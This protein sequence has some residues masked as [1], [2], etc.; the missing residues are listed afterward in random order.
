VNSPVA[1]P[2]FVL[3][4]YIGPE[5]VG[6]D[7]APGFDVSNYVVAFGTFPTANIFLSP[8]LSSPIT[9]EFSASIGNQLG[10]HGMAKLTY[11]N[12]SYYNFIEDFIDD[13]TASGRTDVVYNGTDFGTFDNIVYRNSDLPERQYHAL[14]T[15]ANY[16]PWSRLSL[17]G[18]WTLQLKNNGNFEGEAQN[19]PGISSSLGDYP[20]IL[21]PSRNFPLGRLSGFQRN[22]V[23]LW[24]IYDQPLGKFGSVD[25]APILRVDSGTAYSLFATNVDLSDVQLARDPGYAHLPD[26]GTQTLYFGDRGSQTFPGFALFDLAA[27]YQVPV[28]RTASPWIKV[29]ILNVT[30]NQKLIS[31]DTTVTPDPDSP[32]DANGLPTG[33]IKGPRFG[34]ATANTNYPAWRPGQS[35][36]RTYLLSAGVRF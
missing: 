14:L 10:T 36:G 31:W 32:V 20:E 28:F 8:G 30:N 26:G 33:Y 1:N 23:R 19:Q 9:R 21:V 17:E 34:E 24:A 18:H 6:R 25:L 2:A 4:D 7:F 29:E 12:R 35:G 3:S 11:V 5:G 16:R 13:P 15:Q 27:T 22:K